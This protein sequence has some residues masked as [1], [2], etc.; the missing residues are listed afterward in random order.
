VNAG[1]EPLPLSWYGTTL[2]YEG[3]SEMQGTCD[4]SPGVFYAMPMLLNFI[5]PVRTGPLPT[6]S[7]KVVMMGKSSLKAYVH[8]QAT[9]LERVQRNDDL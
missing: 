3:V 8:F 2:I 7:F 1:E 4:T 6:Y 9:A 5:G